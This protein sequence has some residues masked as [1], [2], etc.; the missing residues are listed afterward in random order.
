MLQ[1]FHEGCLAAAER[2]GSPLILWHTLSEVWNLISQRWRR[3]LDP[4]LRITAPT[5]SP[6][7]PKRTGDLAIG[8][9]IRH[10]F[11]S[12]NAHRADS[13]LVIA[14]LAMGVAASSVVFG[15]VD[16]L[17][18]RPV[19]F[20]GADRLVQ[21]WSVDDSKIQTP[22]MPVEVAARWLERHD[23][24]ASGGVYRG[25]SAL[26]SSQG[27][28]AIIPATAISPGVLETL[29]VRPVVGRTFARDEG[30]PGVDHLVILSD[31]VW[32]SRFG[33]SPDAVGRAM[34][35]NGSDYTVV[36][37][38][39]ADFR[40][41]YGPQRLWFPT[42]VAVS[43]GSG[44]RL[45]NLIA[46]L[47]PG[48]S[49]EMAKQQIAAAGPRM[50]AAAAKPWRYGAIATFVD[51]PRMGDASQ[52]SIW[53]LFGA[54]SLLLV[55]VCLNVANLGLARVFARTRDAA[56]RSA[57]GAS[58]G[59]LMR[60]AFVEHL[61][62]GTLALAV[63]L[64]LTLTGLHLAQ[65]LLPAQFIFSSLHVV[66][67]DGRILAVVVSMA[68]LTPVVAGVV[69]ALAGSAQAVQ[70]ALRLE[71]RSTMGTRRSR[72]FRES[73]VVAEVACAVVLLVSTALLTRSFMRLQSAE[74][75]FDSRNLVSV[76]LSFPRATYPTGVARDLFLDAI[77][78]D[79]SRLPG[80][81][82][83]TA[84]SGVPPN[85]GGVSF[86]TI[87]VDGETKPHDNAIVSVYD[88]RPEFFRTI[89]MPLH[90]GRGFS[91]QDDPARVILSDT[92]ASMLWPGQRA[93]GKRF[94]WDD[95]PE[96]HEVIGVVRTVRE[97]SD[98][99]TSMPQMYQPMVRQAD[100]PPA[101]SS[102]PISGYM[103]LALRVTDPVASMRA[104]RERLKAADPTLV[105]QHLELVDDQLSEEMT[106]PRF[107]LVLMGLFA[108]TGLVLA[109]AGLYGVLSCV[110][111]QRM[112]EIG[113]RLML[114]AE[115][116]A[117]ARH[118]IRG[119][120]V[121]VTMGVVMGAIVAFG[122]ARVIGSLLFKV[123]AHDAASYAVVTLVVLA[124]GLLAA[125]RPARRARRADP[126]T[127]LRSE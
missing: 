34:Q 74:L 8:M 110:V 86:G 5:P 47:A 17:L 31:E 115:P 113:V 94:K 88:V 36:G 127:L 45:V 114:G 16:A 30:A 20:P 22:S 108:G 98:L 92:F 77:L 14:L 117:I 102:G 11:R 28:P 84:A 53:L 49:R 56:I 4:R 43:P 61:V 78:A 3:S 97:T 104:I 9:D 112:R 70:N 99:P 48:V 39:P 100:A 24:F 116:H 1:T 38:M 46:R 51:T 23:L 81:T 55:M 119:G 40:F 37:V 65:T 44:T 96:W 21:V 76:Y 41:P 7:G 19:P 85:D 60:Q 122:V 95:D 6:A 58:R 82:A 35:I 87:H 126:L 123:D 83:A 33:R 124:T 68:L 10:A 118:V 67:L 69:P 52:Q 91:P 57:L 54:T 72:I 73:L 27:D 62:V 2:G 64:P 103:R 120:L 71:T 12:L 89:G 93:V 79:L 111:S 63:A 101:S 15:V 121:S 29:G 13:V 125:W 18:L 25:T 59:R 32:A 50:A 105:V 80:V 106:R 109:A 42:S 66:G 90:D 107:L 75:G 26:V